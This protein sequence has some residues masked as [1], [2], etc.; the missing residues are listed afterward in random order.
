MHP[1]NKKTTQGPA[2]RPSPTSM[3]TET[4]QFLS[5]SIVGAAA[6]TIGACAAVAYIPIPAP[7]QPQVEVVRETCPQPAPLAL[8]T[9]AEPSNPSRPL[10]VARRA[11]GAPRALQC[12]SLIDGMP[13]TQCRQGDPLCVC[14]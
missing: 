10:E 9:T 4:L 13:M 6:A 2:S 11:Y 1:T 7:K 5:G 3:K 12:R 14:E 8:A